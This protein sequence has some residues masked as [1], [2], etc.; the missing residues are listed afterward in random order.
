MTRPPPFLISFASVLNQNFTSAN[1]LTTTSSHPHQIH[2]FV[3]PRLSVTHPYQAV[4]TTVNNTY[5]SLLAHI[6]CLSCYISLGEIKPQRRRG[7]F[8]HVPRP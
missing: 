1:V 6:E 7:E 2:E 3:N 5:L 8:E 4:S